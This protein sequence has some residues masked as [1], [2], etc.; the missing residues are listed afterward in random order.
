MPTDG[1]F[2]CAPE[3]LQVYLCGMVRMWLMLATLVAT[4]PLLLNAQTPSNCPTISITGPAGIVAPGDTATFVVAIDVSEAEK[5]KLGYLW[6]TTNGVLESC[7]SSST[8]NRG[9]QIVRSLRALRG[10]RTFSF[11][12]GLVPTDFR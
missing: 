5:A 8:S 11:P 12:E 1:I 2:F 7:T 3:R 4:A 9:P 6:S 10:L